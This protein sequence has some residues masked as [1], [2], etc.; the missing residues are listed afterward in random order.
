[1]DH[2]LMIGLRIDRQ[3][4]PHMLNTETSGFGDLGAPYNSY[5]ALQRPCRWTFLL[6]ARECALY[7][8]AH[9]GRNSQA[10]RDP[11]LREPDD[12]I[13]DLI[14]SYGFSNNVFRPELDPAHLQCAI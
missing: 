7:A 10:V 5:G 11:D 8:V 6:M 2:V 13:N 14:G 3:Q 12:A 9:G 1:M 4:S